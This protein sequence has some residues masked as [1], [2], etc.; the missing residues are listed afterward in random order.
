MKKQAIIS[1]GRPI[2]ISRDGGTTWFTTAIKDVC[3]DIISIM[4]PYQKTPYIKIPL[5]LSKGDKLIVR[6]TIENFCFIFETRVADCK[7]KY[8]HLTYPKKLERVK[9][10]KNIRLPIRLYVRYSC[11]GSN[12]IHFRNATTIDLSCGGMKLLV[13]E[14]IKPNTQILVAFKLPTKEN[15][16]TIAIKGRV[17]HCK[18]VDYYDDFYHVGIKFE[19]ITEQLESQ[20]ARYIFNK[21]IEMRKAKVY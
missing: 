13:V 17:T 4:L 8:Y 1:P 16:N 18:K 9:R 12:L 10:R 3:E 15:P 6:L 21:M 5:V 20:I 7:D 2:Q 11:Y 19:D 14:G